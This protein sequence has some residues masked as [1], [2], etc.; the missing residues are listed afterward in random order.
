MKIRLLSEVVDDINKKT[1]T[2]HIYNAAFHRIG[3]NACGM[4]L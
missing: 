4:V 3:C 1:D 2:M